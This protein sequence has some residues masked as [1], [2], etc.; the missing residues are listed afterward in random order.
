M[1]TTHPY[2]SSRCP[3]ASSI[4]VWQPRPGLNPWLDGLKRRLKDRLENLPHGL[5][6]HPVDPIRDPH[7]ALPTTRLRNARPANRAR[8][9]APIQQAASQPRTGDRPLL[10]QLADRLPVRARRSLEIGRASCREDALIAAGA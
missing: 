2:P 4:A 10:T 8:T 3:L 5:P 7:P 1:S 9:I 6:D